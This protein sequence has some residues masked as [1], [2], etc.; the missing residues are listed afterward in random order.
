MDGGRKRTVILSAAKDLYCPRTD[1]DSS[2]R[3]VVTLHTGENTLCTQKRKS[4]FFSPATCHLPPTTCHLSLPTY[5]FS[6]AAI[7]A[8]ALQ[9]SSAT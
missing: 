2:L 7:T 6:I 4:P 9:R 1:R 5:R 3:S 8:A